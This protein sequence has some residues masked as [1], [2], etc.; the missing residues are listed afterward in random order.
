MTVDRFDPAGS[1]TAANALAHRL[2]IDIAEYIDRNNL[3][4]GAHLPA[5]RLAELLNVSRFPIRTALRHLEDRGVLFS[6]RNSGYFYSGRRDA[7]EAMRPDIHSAE[8]DPLFACI[9]RDRMRGHLGNMFT[10]ADLARRYGMTRPQVQSTLF[11]M[12]RD[13]IVQQRPGYGWA[14]A[15]IITSPEA[16]EHG[17]SYRIAIETAALVEPGYKVDVTAFNRWRQLLQEILKN[18]KS[19]GQPSIFEIGSRFHE[20]L[21]RCS[22]NPF[23]LEATQRYSRQ[24]RLIEYS[25]PTGPRYVVR[26]T[27]EHLEIM[28]RLEDGDRLGASR[29]MWRH[30]DF[31]RSR[32]LRHLKG[33]SDDPEVIAHF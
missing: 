9:A 21:L 30:L 8:E 5:Q 10:E 20:M 32:K 23:F 12:A 27:E 3:E 13:G 18:P 11:Q 28:D 4:A 29:L 16:F 24:R 19:R 15:D 6:K 22:G 14:F 17:F 31:T 2:A 25:I 7:L 26:Q 1:A 33:E